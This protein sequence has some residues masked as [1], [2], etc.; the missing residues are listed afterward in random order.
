MFPL[1][2]PVLK[3]R[4]LNRILPTLLADNVK[5]RE[6]Q[7]DG[8]YTRVKRDPDVPPLR[9]QLRFLTESQNGDFEN[10]VPD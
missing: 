7:P 6:M 9:A 2:E 5:A 1:I 3:R 4:M 10:E 8:T